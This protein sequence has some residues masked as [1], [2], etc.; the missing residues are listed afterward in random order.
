V[1]EEEGKE[2][3]RFIKDLSLSPE[4]YMANDYDG[5]IYYVTPGAAIHTEFDEL[6]VKTIRITVEVPEGQETVG[7]SEIRVLGR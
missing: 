2:V 7:I 4:Y 3:I 5:S 1:C 6:N